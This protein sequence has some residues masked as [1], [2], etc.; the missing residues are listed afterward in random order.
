MTRAG[1][2]L[3]GLLGLSACG[4]SQLDARFTPK[5]E[6]SETQVAESIA[7]APL[8]SERAVAVGLSQDPVRLCAWDLRAGT[9]LWERPVDAKSAP[10]VAGDAVV[11]HEG[12]SFVV[13]DLGT[14]ELRASV[15]DGGGALVGADAEQERVV[16]TTAH[17]DEDAR[18]QIT[19]VEGTSVRWR[20]ALPQP[21]G[22]PALVNGRVVAPWGTQRLSVF[23][24]DGSEVARW[25]FHNMVLG[26][27]QVA[28]EGVYIG[29]H[30]LL[31]VN[32]ELPDHRDGPVNL[33]APR[34]RSLPGQPGLLRDGYAP[35]P[36]PDGADHKLRLAWQ[37]DE[38]VV[39]DDLVVFHFYR[40]V[41]GFAAGEDAVRWVRHF[42]HD[43]VGSH[44]Q[45]GGVF[46]ADA[47]GLVRFID[48]QGATRF[49]RALG[50]P[51]R[52]VTLRPG[53][54]LS[55]GDP[56]AS[57]LESASELPTG[58]LHDQLL[59][60]TQLDD[61]R[62]APGKA[63]AVQYLART[64]APSVTRELIALCRPAQENRD[65]MQ[66]AACDELSKREVGG[67]DVLETLRERASWL[68]GVP[69]P[70]VAALAQAAARMNLKQAGPLLLSHAEDP[71]TPAPA[72]EQVFLALSALQYRPAIPQ[73]ERFVRMHHAEPAGSELT[74]ALQA[75]LLALGA[76]Q[77]EKARSTVDYIAKDEFALPPV[78][79]T[80]QEVLVALDAPPA[81]KAEAKAEAKQAKKGK[82]VVTIEEAVLTTITEPRPYALDAPAV[83]KA[84]RPLRAGLLRCLEADPAKPKSMRM[85][86]IV[87]GSGNVEGFL[88][89]PTSLQG[90][91]EPI[92]RNARFPA[93][94]LG[95][96]HLVHTLQ[97]GGAQAE[98]AHAPAAPQEAA[99]AQAP[100][101]TTAPKGK[102]KPKARAR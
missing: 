57:T 62:L 102:A 60:L 27:A 16:I 59:E 36:P 52:V 29:Q 88:V 51:M 30:G 19:F 83:E 85:S 12:D 90:C 1:W 18:G 48:T 77:G 25:H 37:P 4:A 8:R 44:K 72:L 23:A 61:A 35:V 21:V 32:P 93:T 71:H 63:L 95:R 22:A 38:A 55:E 26:Q 75:A 54:F 41:F 40:M 2:L 24:Q 28:G 58:S 49:K 13:R 15:R 70:P 84:F 34:K 80:A 39:Q 43:V 94:R 97:A 56:A 53:G 50:R 3:A 47:S 67:V 74:P 79:K 6:L 46:V 86:M 73:L 78:R 14:G 101:G 31:R 65:P 11:L 81:P 92:L 96:Q 20:K 82:E 5:P 76:L 91:A 7:R 33:V 42:E 69:R 64:D 9:L 10:L 98:A 45:R 17:P 66:L 99:A 87:A 89:T 68:E 100:K